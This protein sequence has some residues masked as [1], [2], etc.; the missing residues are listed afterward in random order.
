MIILT[1]FGIINSVSEKLKPQEKPITQKAA[2]VILYNGRSEVLLVHHRD[3]P[4]IL[5]GGRR[6]PKEEDTIFGL[7]NNTLWRELEEELGLSTEQIN[8]LK[9]RPFLCFGFTTCWTKDGILRKE[10]VSAIYLGGNNRINTNI[11]PLSEEIFE[12]GW[13]N[14]FHLP[15]NIDIPSNTISSIVR[16]RSILTGHARARYRRF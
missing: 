16:L 7:L 14:F 13:Y 1:L 15:T 8:H 9:D 6:N 5:P 12:S 2:K 3:G 10:V 4:W 11:N